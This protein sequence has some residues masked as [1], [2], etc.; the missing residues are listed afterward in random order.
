[1]L[2]EDVIYHLRNTGKKWNVLEYG[3]KHRSNKQIKKTVKSF[4]RCTLIWI[5]PQSSLCYQ[6]SCPDSGPPKNSLGIVG[7]WLSRPG[8][9]EIPKVPLQANINTCGSDHTIKIPS[10]AKRFHFLRYDFNLKQQNM[11]QISV[12]FNQWLIVRDI[13]RK[14]RS[15]NRWHLGELQNIETCNVW[16]H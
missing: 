8:L 4:K 1:M 12:L 6:D 15:F 9:C 16:K 11:P 10:S 5:E 2:V 3:V 13:F 7:K 14:K